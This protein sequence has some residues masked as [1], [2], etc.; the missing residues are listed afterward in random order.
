MA[1]AE[2]PY[3]LAYRRA[4][5]ELC[6]RFESYLAAD[7]ALAQSAEEVNQAL[8]AHDARVNRVFDGLTARVARRNPAAGKLM[9]QELAPIRAMLEK[10]VADLRWPH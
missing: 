4:V 8:A 2:A 1:A 6:D 10:R 3:E 9:Q 5:D 7:L